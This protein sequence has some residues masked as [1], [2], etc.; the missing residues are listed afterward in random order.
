[1]SDDEAMSAEF[2]KLFSG[3]VTVG[4]VALKKYGPRSWEDFKAGWQAHQKHIRSLKM[5]NDSISPELGAMGTVEQVMKNRKEFIEKVTKYILYSGTD[6]DRLRT[7]LIVTEEVAREMGL[8][9]QADRL[10]SE[11]EFLDKN[12]ETLLNPYW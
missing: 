10:K 1:M 3:Y 11:I 9:D 12:H 8:T 4:G 6:L 2:E 5:D 7:M